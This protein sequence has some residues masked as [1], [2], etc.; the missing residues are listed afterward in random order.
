[1]P[2]HKGGGIDDL[3]NYEADRDVQ[4]AARGPVAGVT[5]VVDKHAV[6]RAATPNGSQPV[7]I[8]RASFSVALDTVAAVLVVFDLA[9][10]VVR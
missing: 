10:C 6:S 9:V 7:P 8:R 3:L 4:L 2:P 5:A 1:M